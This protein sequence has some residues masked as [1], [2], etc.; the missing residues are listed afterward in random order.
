MAQTL[1]KYLK[2]TKKTVR[3]F[4]A[5]ILVDPESVRRYSRGKRIPR[6]DVMKRIIAATDGAVTADS[7]FSQSVSDRARAA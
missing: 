4:A 2:Q 3:E 6:P 5:E 7:F 1:T